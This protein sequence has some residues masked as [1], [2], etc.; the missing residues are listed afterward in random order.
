MLT[1]LTAS[2]DPDI[3]AAQALLAQADTVD[4]ALAQVQAPPGGS[5]ARSI[6][7]RM[8]KDP[9]GTMADIA[10]QRRHMPDDGVFA[11]L[12]ALGFCAA[13]LE[14]HLAEAQRLY[15]KAIAQSQKVLDHAR[16]L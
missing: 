16:A 12:Q 2:Y 10:L 15:A 4:D 5:A 9:A 6:I 13:D 8:E 11:I 7:A 3:A 1:P 14:P